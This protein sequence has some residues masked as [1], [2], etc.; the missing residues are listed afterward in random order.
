M[1][2]KLIVL[3]LLPLLIFGL[4]AQVGAVQGADPD[5]QCSITFLMEFDGTFLDG[6]KVT[7]YRVGQISP[8]GDKFVLVD[9]LPQGEVSLDSLEDPKLAE[10]L[11]VLAIEHNLSAHSAP[12]VSGKAVFSD[13]KTGVYVVSQRPGEETQGYCA[14][15]AFLVSLPQWKED[16]YIY[17]VT[18]FPKV[19]VKPSPTQPTQVTEPTQPVEDSYLPQTGQLNWPVPVLAVLGFAVFLIGWSLY[20]KAKRRGI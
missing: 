15:N 17:D 16:E 13:L 7:L 12:I 3:L 19:S 11:S 10:T 4:C 8:D 5:K 18:A 6:G 20:S 1:Q 9:T 14:I 2:K